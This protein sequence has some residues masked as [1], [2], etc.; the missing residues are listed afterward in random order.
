LQRQVDAALTS[1]ELCPA[2]EVVLHDGYS[3]DFVV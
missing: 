1:L 3:L 2:E